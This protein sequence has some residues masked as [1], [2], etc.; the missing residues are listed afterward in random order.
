M[1]GREKNNY[2]RGWQN[3]LNAQYTPTYILSGIVSLILY[4]NVPQLKLVNIQGAFIPWF[5]S[6]H[7]ARSK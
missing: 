4:V 5:I 7:S 3:Y 1:I 2:K 6:S